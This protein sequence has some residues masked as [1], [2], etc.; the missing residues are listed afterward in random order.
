MKPRDNRMDRQD[1]DIDAPQESDLQ[2][3][4]DIDFETCPDCGKSVPESIARCPHC[5]SWIEGPSPAKDRS[6]GWFWPVMVAILIGII[7]VL[8]SGL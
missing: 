3:G 5:G 6:R 2:D 4:G 7:L 8:W 1:D